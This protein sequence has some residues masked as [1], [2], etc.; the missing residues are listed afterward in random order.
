[1]SVEWCHQLLDWFNKRN[2][3]ILVS[4]ASLEQ[5]IEQNLFLD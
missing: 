5:F 4:L 1:M 2:Q 3:H